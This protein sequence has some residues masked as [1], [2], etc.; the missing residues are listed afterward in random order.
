MAARKA[1]KKKGAAG[2]KASAKKKTAAKKAPSGKK[3]AAK[4]KKSSPKKKAAQ[5]KPVE[6]AAPAEAAPAEPMLPVPTLGAVVGALFARDRERLIESLGHVDFERLARYLLGYDWSGGHWARFNWSRVMGGLDGEGVDAARDRIRAGLSSGEVRTLA[7]ALRA[8]EWRG[9]AETAPLDEMLWFGDVAELVVSLYN[10]EKTEVVCPHCPYPYRDVFGRLFHLEREITGRVV[11]LLCPFEGDGQHCPPNL[12]ADSWT[13]I[14]DLT[15]QDGR[16]VRTDGL[17]DGCVSAAK[18]GFD[19]S[20]VPEGSGAVVMT[21]QERELVHKQHAGRVPAEPASP[22][23]LLIVS[24]AG[25]RAGDD[26][27]VV[28]SGYYTQGDGPRRPM[29]IDWELNETNSEVSF[30]CTDLDGRVLD[31]DDQVITIDWIAS[32]R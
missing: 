22:D 20:Q 27:Q 32:T 24:L 8:V 16:A 31:R 5:R 18:V 13:R 11:P 4:K 30:R 28:A 19:I 23:G 26:V 15:G 17:Q 29:V 3:A 25:F 9:L 6:P 2:K 1:A 7:R 14:D 12:L 21:E 10:F